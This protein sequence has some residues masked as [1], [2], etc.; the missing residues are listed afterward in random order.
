MEKGMATF[1]MEKGMASHGQLVGCQVLGEELTAWTHGRS[2][3]KLS[4][5]IEPKPRHDYSEVSPI[6]ANGAYSQE[7]K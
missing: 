1:E 6:T 7:S 4:R 5:A 2:L 3:E